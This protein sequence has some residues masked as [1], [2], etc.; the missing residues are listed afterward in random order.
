M[1]W[2]AALVIAA[3]A[4]VA[5]AAATY[6]VGDE[7]ADTTLATAD[8]KETKLSSY[9]GNAV[10]LFFYGHWARHAG[11]EAKEVEAIRKGRAKQKLTVLGVARDAKAEDAKKFAD[12]NKLG[13]VQALDPKSEFY[14]R[15]ATKGL[16]WVA[17][18]DGKRKLKYSAAGIDEEAIETALTAVLG[19]KDAGGEKDGGGKK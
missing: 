19:A 16:P 7:V 2:S 17:L 13:F 11:E 15:F 6:K 9:E 3:A 1:K 14:A 8:G 18:L 10:I 12:D 5:W 4:S